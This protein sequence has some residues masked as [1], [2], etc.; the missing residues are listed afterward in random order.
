MKIKTTHVHPPIPHRQ[1]DWSATTEDYDGTG[2][3]GWGPT[4][5]EAIDDLKEQLELAE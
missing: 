4:E 3:I 1:Y 2:P 5:I